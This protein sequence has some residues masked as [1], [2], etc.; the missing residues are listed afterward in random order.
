VQDSEF[1]KDEGRRSN[2]RH[3]ILHYSP[4]DFVCA[5]QVSSLECNALDV[6]YTVSAIRFIYLALRYRTFVSRLGTYTRHDVQ[7][8][9]CGC[10]LYQFD[11]GLE[12]V[13][14]DSAPI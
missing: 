8:A 12:L 2:H 10:C 5:I 9:K 1:L 14:L 4:S 6:V 7:R 13:A 11:Y 3:R